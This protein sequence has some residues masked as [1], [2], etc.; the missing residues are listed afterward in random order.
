MCVSFILMFK[1]K[2]K[3]KHFLFEHSPKFD[4]KRAYLIQKLP[5]NE[6]NAPRTVGT[7]VAGQ[8]YWVVLHC[9]GA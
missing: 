1:K 9:T 4:F 2:P 6:Y 3:K 7:V 5:K 8:L